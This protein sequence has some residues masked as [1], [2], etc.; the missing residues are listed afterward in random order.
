MSTLSG[1]LTDTW[2]G[3]ATQMPEEKQ[4]ELHSHRQRLSQCHSDRTVTVL[5]HSHSLDVPGGER[6][7]QSS[8]DSCLAWTGHEGQTSSQQEARAAEGGD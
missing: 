5:E 3:S 1:R 2:T 7:R 8:G 6:V 4:E